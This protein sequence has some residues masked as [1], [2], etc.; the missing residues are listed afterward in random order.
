MC[1]TCFVHLNASFNF[2]QLAMLEKY[3]SKVPNVIK[4]KAL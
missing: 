3:V 2:L 1:A 4:I